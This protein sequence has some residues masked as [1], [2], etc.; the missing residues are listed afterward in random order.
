MYRRLTPVA[1]HSRNSS[2]GLCAALCYHYFEQPST[3]TYYRDR[4]VR[5]AASIRPRDASVPPPNPPFSAT[6]LTSLQPFL[7]HPRC[8]TTDAYPNT[9]SPFSSYPNPYDRRHADRPG[10]V[11]R[12]HKRAPPRKS[13]RST[14][15]TSSVAPCK[16]RTRLCCKE[17]NCME[18]IKP[19][20]LC[21]P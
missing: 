14:S 10:H 9:S 5:V 13:R 7:I 20:L 6:R 15:R 4:S 18:P 3:H 2:S 12:R 21:F 19:T 8:H 1:G 16:S 11:G 17:F